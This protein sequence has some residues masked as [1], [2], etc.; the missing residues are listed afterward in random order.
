MPDTSSKAF[1]EHLGVLLRAHFPL[2]VIDSVEEQRV[3]SRAAQIAGQLGM[4]CLTWDVITGFT[5]VH[6]DRAM[7]PATDPQDVISRLR[8]MSSDS[9]VILK[10]FHHEW[11][12]HR[13]LRAMRNY[14]QRAGAAGPTVIVLGAGAVLPDALRDTAV[15]LELP[16][17]TR[18]ELQQ[19]LKEV[20]STHWVRHE[21]DAAGTEHL[22]DSA[23]GLT[24]EQARRVFT[25]AAVG[26]GVLDAR[27]LALVLEEKKAI[28][29]SSGA[30]EY[31][32]PDVGPGDV[33]GLDA[34]K[35]WLRL[36]ERGFS[37]A[38]RD[39]GLPPPKGIAL[40]GLPGT[41]KSLTAKTIGALWQVP[42]LRLDIGAIYSS[43]MGESEKRARHALRLAETIAPCVVWIDELDKAISTGSNDNGTSTRV[44]GT[45]LTWMSEKTAPCFVV[46]TA[47]DIS[48]LP[49]ELLRRG[50]FD[51]IFFLD[52]PTLA[53]RREILTVHVR[54]S[55]R[56]PA[57]YD[58]DAVAAATDGFVGAELAQTV[59]D[60]LVV[61][62]DAGR[63]L[64]SADLLRCAGAVVP[65]A[66]SQR[67]RVGALRAW[68]AEGRAQPASS[69]R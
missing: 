50:R 36:R 20:T 13:V 31:L 57:A 26:D 1:T 55:G 61:A 9:L 43:F 14:A 59:L 38:A 10:D 6:E 19:V 42:L 35:E 24:L 25:K 18:E 15:T 47:N 58:L 68:L 28:I 65:L 51:E 66:V 62:F 45:L 12:D 56:Q 34:L 17:P 2:I 5:S 69:G 60:G 30:L 7:A 40:I 11:E 67:E 53:E 3:V 22:V 23:L 39:F 29:A 64:T 44:M 4:R 41:G 63:D 27:D 52:L 49:A 33:G 48:R 46:A 16:P 32:E 37:A 21:L 54:R 8:A